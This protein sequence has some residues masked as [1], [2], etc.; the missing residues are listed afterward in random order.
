M[1]TYFTSEESKLKS[2]P[3]SIEEISFMSSLLYIGA[4][5]GALLSGW[6]VN[7]I[8]RKWCLLVWLFPA[9]AASALILVAESPLLLFAAR[10]ISGTITGVSLVVPSIFTAEIVEGR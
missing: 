6:L 2:G 3:M 9:I 1:T 8:G 7:A 4:I 10:A 5:V